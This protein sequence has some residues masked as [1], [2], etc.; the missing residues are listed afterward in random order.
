MDFKV[1]SITKF[2]IVGHFEFPEYKEIN[3]TRRPMLTNVIFGKLKRY[4]S[5]IK[6]LGSQWYSLTIK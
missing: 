4:S 3:C 2:I 1:S 5:E 6:N